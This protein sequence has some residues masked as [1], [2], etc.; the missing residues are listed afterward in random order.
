[1]ERSSFSTKCCPDF[2]LD[3]R[4]L[5]LNTASSLILRRGAKPLATGSRSARLPAVR[6]SWSLAE[7][8]RQVDPRVF[9][10]SS[11]HGGE[12]HVLAAALAVIREYREKD[13]IAN[14]RRLNATVAAGIQKS[15]ED[16]DLSGLYRGACRIVAHRFYVS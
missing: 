1:M 7:F 10:L 8:G 2:G 11:T 12:H 14:L 6:I 5:T 9:L 13:V 16:A 4:A 3:C 15:I